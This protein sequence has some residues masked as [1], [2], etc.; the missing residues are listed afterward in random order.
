MSSK[1]RPSVR[2]SLPASE[3]G[4]R[5][6][7]GTPISKSP[8]PLIGETTGGDTGTHISAPIRAGLGKLTPSLAAGVRKVS[9][10][11]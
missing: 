11:R 1:V 8:D 7:T 4:G 6:I 10:T 5:P 3:M 9:S 2:V